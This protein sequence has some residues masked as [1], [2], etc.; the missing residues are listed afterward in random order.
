MEKREVFE[1]GDAIKTVFAWLARFEQAM[2]YNPL[3]EL[4]LRVRRLEVALAESRS[5]SEPTKA[6]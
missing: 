6:E 4:Q 2:D 3:H 5:T 1:M